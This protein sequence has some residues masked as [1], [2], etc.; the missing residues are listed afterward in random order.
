[1]VRF[2]LIL[3]SW[4]EDGSHF[5]FYFIWQRKVYQEHKISGFFCEG[6]CPLLRISLSVCCSHCVLEP[7][8]LV[9]GTY[10]WLCLGVTS[11][12]DWETVMSGMK[13]SMSITCSSISPALS[14]CCLK[15]ITSEGSN[16]YETEDLDFH[17]CNLTSA[18]QFITPA[19]SFLLQHP[20]ELL[21]LIFLCFHLPFIKIV[22][23]LQPALFSPQHLP[24]HCLFRMWSEKS[25]LFSIIFETFFESSFNSSFCS[26]AISIGW[27]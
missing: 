8:I 17:G 16:Y 9:L 22:T 7:C 21:I 15:L 5:A 14:R 20:K 11:G 25:K 24:W 3:F 27:F 13:Q 10:F 23:K 4:H 2:W 12:S 6:T 18:S 19:K 26:P 1:M